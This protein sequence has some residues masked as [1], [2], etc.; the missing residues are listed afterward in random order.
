MI[1]QDRAAFRVVD[2]ASLTLL[3]RNAH[4]MKKSAFDQLASNV[5]RDGMLSSIPLCHALTDGSLEVLS[6]NHR[7][8]AAITAGIERIV[9]LVIPQQDAQRRIARQLSHNSLVGEDDRQI[10]A[11]L[12]KELQ[13]ID[14]KLY[15]G[16]DSQL[17]GEL[18]KIKFCGFSAER[19]RTECI[20]LWFLPEEVQTL[21]DL[22][23]EAD[24]VAA[25]DITYVAPLTKYK[26]LFD[27]LLSTKR[28]RNIKNTAVAFGYL[29]DRISEQM[30]PRNSD[31]APEFP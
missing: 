30:I 16:L 11:E 25:S 3:K 9:V 28:C 12:W 1:Y 6:G 20:V 13:S 22:I 27:A 10:L 29:I 8:R 21:D 24:K 7:V 15:S 26:A 5:A 23:N 17:A 31:S 19:I 14:A 2:P 4:F 18:E